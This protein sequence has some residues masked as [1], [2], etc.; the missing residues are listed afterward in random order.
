MSSKFLKWTIALAG[1]AAGTAAVVGKLASDK[2]KNEDLDAFLLPDTDEDQDLD[3]TTLLTSDIMSW[4]GKSEDDLQV[5]L[6]FGVDNQES[7]VSFQEALAKEGLSSELDSENMTVHVIYTGDY[8]L[9]GLN[10]LAS[11]LEDTSEDASAD[12]QGFEFE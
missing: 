5:T 9:E 8:S 12:Y 10:F 3:T 1:I 4:L 7:A 6:T 11:I 2:K